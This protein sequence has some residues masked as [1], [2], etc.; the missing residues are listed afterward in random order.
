MAKT[1]IA[2]ALIAAQLLPWASGALYMCVASDG[3][4]GVDGGPAFC[5]HCERHEVAE[6]STC[7]HAGCC[8]ERGATVPCDEATALAATCDCQH[9]LL[10]Q[11]QTTTPARQSALE[12]ERLPLVCIFDVPATGSGALVDGVENSLGPG[13]SHEQPAHL[14]A[15]SAVIL[16]C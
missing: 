1:L 11:A 9:L 10:S 6:Q 12:V 3:S 8:H 4:V 13:V 2:S 15:L 14:R 7:C 5:S 16:R